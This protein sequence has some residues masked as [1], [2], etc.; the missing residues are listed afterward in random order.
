MQ[1]F[2]Q[3]KYKTV[4]RTLLKKSTT[5]FLLIS[6]N[7]E[8]V[9]KENGH[10][11]VDVTRRNQCQACRFKKC[12]QVNMKRDG[13]ISNIVITHLT[14]LVNFII[15]NKLSFIWN[16]VLILLIALMKINSILLNNNPITYY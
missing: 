1:R 4:G 9:C 3:E 2:F 14:H 12:L 15:I 10:C 6:R 8:Y 16:E 11:V 7:M 5:N 13:K